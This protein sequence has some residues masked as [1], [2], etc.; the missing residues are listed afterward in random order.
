[1]SNLSYLYNFSF[2]QFFYKK[3]HPCT[4]LLFLITFIF[5][6]ILTNDI[7]I[8]L[9]LIVFNIILLLNSNVNL[10]LIIRNI[11]NMRYLILF[12]FLLNIFYIPN[13][14]NDLLLLLIIIT[15][16]NL[17][18]YTTSTDE[19]LNSF[20]PFIKQLEFFNI[21]INELINMINLSI[22]F[23]PDILSIARIIIKNCEVRGIY[24]FKSSFSDKL[25]IINALIIPLFNATI[26]KSNDLSYNLYFRFY[27]KYNFIYHKKNY[28]IPDYFLISFLIILIIFWRVYE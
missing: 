8:S 24:F 5:I 23:I 21:N 12:L 1:M 22:K 4:K 15:S 6:G 13:F 11:L 3:T 2:L 10:L 17:Y 27:D 16:C 14:F 25:K 28:S 19:I 20:Y 18:T 9:T 7:Y 26:K